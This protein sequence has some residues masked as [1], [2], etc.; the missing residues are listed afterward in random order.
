MA[1]EIDVCDGIYYNK[2]SVYRET[3]KNGT[4][5]ERKENIEFSHDNDDS[6]SEGKSFCS[7]IVSFIVCLF[8]RK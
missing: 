5:K 2:Q 6:Q 3:N 1:T 4:I 8:I 7:T